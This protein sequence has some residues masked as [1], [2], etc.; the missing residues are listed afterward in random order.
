[1]NKGF[2]AKLA[3]SNIKKNSQ[4]YIPYILTCILTIMMFYIIRGL[5]MNEDIRNGDGGSSLIMILNLGSWVVI[6]F[7]V[8][9]LFYT[10]S[11]LIKRRKKEFGLF[12]VLG[13]E[14]KHL[15]RVVLLESIYV[16][17]I[18]LASG[19]ISGIVFS[20]LVYMV[21][22]KM[23]QFPV[24][25]SFDI[26]PKAI[27]D[28][29]MLFLAIFVINYINTLRQI[30]LANPIEL[31]KGGNVGEKEPKTK[32]LIAIVGFICLGAGYYIAITVESPLSALLLFFVAVVLVII[33]TY[34]LFTAGSIVI[35]KMLRKN[36]KYYYQANHFT[37]VS[38]MM[39][40]MKQNAAGL[41]SICVLS[42]GVLI[43]VSTTLSLYLGLEDSLRW[44]YPRN[45]VI[46]SSGMEGVA[47]EVD[48][49]VNEVLAET[50]IK[51]ENLLKYH[52]R[53][54]ML[55]QENEKFHYDEDATYNFGLGTNMLTALMC[56]PL[57]DY[58]QLTGKTETLE[59]NEVLIYRGKGKKLDDRM[60]IGELDIE[61]KE[62]LNEFPIPLG[63]EA[64]LTDIYY[65]IIPDTGFLDQVNKVLNLTDDTESALVYSYGFDLNEE[66]EPEVHSALA[67][68]LREKMADVTYWCYISSVE[69]NRDE[70][71]SFD[72][73][74]FFLGIFL[75][76][77]FLMATVLII[78]YKQI[79][80]GYDDR[81]RYQIMKKVGM[82][83]K[84]VRRSIR[85]Q[86]VSVFALP[87]IMAGIHIMCAFPMIGK[88]LMVMDLFNTKLFMLCTAGTM[89]VFAIGY[90]FIYSMT[91]KTYYK[92]VS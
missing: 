88:L 5:G 19:I 27:A 42:T 76:L 52:Y 32:W 72:G 13:M 50:G 7:S 73:G 77:L 1:M 37:S 58:N 86:V 28:T 41:A 79:S 17:F 61:I 82:S 84:E 53:E 64:L 24:K 66:A 70:F 8:I 81:E 46:S 38:G 36:K 91:A 92:I 29:C 14:K 62:E 69:Q 51:E 45:I 21:L 12:N 34:C 89:V 63:E 9:F 31:L 75:G 33:G 23:L 18:S 83:K 30:H 4:T 44:S 71:Y 26:A 10:N 59:E 68:S 80:E 87:L 56:I 43:L 78:Y 11:F 39:Y 60:Q 49:A 16:S 40:R 57:D 3:V 65:L 67:D 35:L 6:I 54:Y 15:G 48:Q 20:Q 25:I 2:Y 22:M 55:M 90:G 74:L 47:D 85:S